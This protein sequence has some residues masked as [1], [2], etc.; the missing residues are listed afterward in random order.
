MEELLKEI[1]R[2]TALALEAAALVIVALGSVDAIVQ[3]VRARPGA[4]VLT[5][6]R[7]TVLVHLGAWLVLALEFELAAD[8]VRTAI[9][10]TWI[11]L[12]RLAAIAVIRTFLNHFLER[13]LARLAA[14]DS[15]ASA[16]PEARRV[17]L[18]L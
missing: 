6:R 3:G 10:P 1:G 18:R 14:S 7:R 5:G 4:R 15:T 13:D 16:E 12:G 9:A 2:Y 11:E 17:A 8:V